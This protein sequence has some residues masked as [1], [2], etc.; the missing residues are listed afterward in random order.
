MTCSCRESGWQSGCFKSS[1]K[2]LPWVS[3]ALVASSR[4]D[5]NW[6]N[7]SISR[8]CARSIRIL[9]DAFFIALVCAAPPTRDTERPTLTAGLI[10]E[11]KRLLSKKICPS[12]MEIT[13]VGMYADTSPAC[14]S[15]IGSAVIEPPPS[16]S[17]KRL[18]RSKSLECK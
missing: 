2:A 16:S 12:V 8:Y 17:D 10:P 3:C 5:A 1:I 11:L 18:L 13:L 15:M 14:V 4:S 6:V 7:T 9:P